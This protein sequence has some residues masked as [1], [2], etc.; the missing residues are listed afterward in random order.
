LFVFF[1]F[2]TNNIIHNYVYSINKEK[3]NKIEYYSNIQNADKIKSIVKDELVFY[4][5]MRYALF[6]QNQQLIFGYDYNIGRF[7]SLFLPFKIS[8]KLAFFD[9]SNYDNYFKNGKV[10]YIINEN[11]KDD[12]MK[13]HFSRY[14]KYSVVSNLCIYTY[15]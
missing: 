1:L 15:E 9:A 13:L 5:N 6:A 4:P 11:G 2:L 12:F 14:Q 8:T 3:K 7:M 10:K